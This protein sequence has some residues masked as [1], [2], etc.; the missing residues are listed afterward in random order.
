MFSTPNF[1]C[2]F[3]FSVDNR[4]RN[5]YYKKKLKYTIVFVFGYIHVFG[6]KP[7]KIRIYPK[8]NTIVHK[9]MKALTNL[10]TIL[11][12]FIFVNF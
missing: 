7:P 4:N 6:G 2:F 12:H 10:Y 9:T 3:V 5:R 11:A 1:L 8:K